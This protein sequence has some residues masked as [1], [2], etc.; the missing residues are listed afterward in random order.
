MK[1]NLLKLKRKH[2]FW[3]ELFYRD[4]LNKRAI[5]RL[6]KKAIVLLE[7]KADEYWGWDIDREAYDACI[8]AAHVICETQNRIC[9]ESD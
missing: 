7:Q 9:N 8:I 5:K 2:L 1:A 4:E 3:F 6:S